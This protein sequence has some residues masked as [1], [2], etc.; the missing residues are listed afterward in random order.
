MVVSGQKMTKEQLA[1]EKTL[2]QKNLLYY[3]GLHG[4]PVSH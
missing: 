2:L 3:E 1:S 4:R